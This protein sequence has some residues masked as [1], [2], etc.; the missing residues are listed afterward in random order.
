MSY[1]KTLARV[2]ELYQWPAMAKDVKFYCESCLSCNQRRKPLKKA[3]VQQMPLVESRARHSIWMNTHGYPLLKHAGGLPTH[4]H[5]LLIG[6]V[7][8]PPIPIGH[9]LIPKLPIHILN[10]MNSIFIEKYQD[11]NEPVCKGI[12]GSLQLC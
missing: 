1:E 9:Y 11:W 5:P 8:R 10:C 7:A 2:R 4:A 6:L 3:P 12:C